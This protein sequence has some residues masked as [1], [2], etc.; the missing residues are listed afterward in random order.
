MT[1]PHND[2]DDDVD[3]DGDLGS[4]HGGREAARRPIAYAPREVPT[5][6]GR[7]WQPVGRGSVEVPPSVRPSASAGTAS[8][9]R[10]DCSTPARLTDRQSL[11]LSAFLPTWPAVGRVSAVIRVSAEP[12]ARSAIDDVLR[13]TVHISLLLRD[14]WGY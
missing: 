8:P 10:R 1:K 9:R 6:G 7:R 14:P 2:D 11:K 13:R 12:T 5:A 4:C 3:D